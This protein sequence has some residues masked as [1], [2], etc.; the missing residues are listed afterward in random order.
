MFDGLVEPELEKAVDND[1]GLVSAIGSAMTW[2]AAR[3]HYAMQLCD[4]LVEALENVPGV[5]RSEQLITSG[6]VNGIDTAADSCATTHDIG[7][8]QYVLKWQGLAQML[9]ADHQAEWAELASERIEGCLTFELEFQSYI[10]FSDSGLEFTAEM[11]ATF[12][13]VIPEAQAQVMGW[14]DNESDTVA[15]APLTYTPQLELTWDE[16][17]E[18]DLTRVETRLASVLLPFVNIPKPTRQVPT[19]LNPTDE[20]DTEPGTATVEPDK[21]FLV[22]FPLE[23]SE[24]FETACTDLL[25]GPNP[26]GAW[27][28]WTF[29]ELHAEELSP[30]WEGFKIPL[31]PGTGKLYGRATFERNINVEVRIFEQTTFDLFHN[32]P[33]VP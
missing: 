15:F 16:G 9:F 32:A 18:V 30:N 20:V 8:V 25:G 2:N 13:P 28:P 12:Q 3:E 19:S 33:R 24:F 14:V 21:P 11:K 7:E 17:C 29:N 27:G 4:D 22:F 10:E 26:D 31:E 6:L 1:L 23:G 5:E